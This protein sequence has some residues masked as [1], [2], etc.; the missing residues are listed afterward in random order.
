MKS[1]RNQELLIYP[2]ERRQRPVSLF[3]IISQIRLFSLRDS[4]QL[5]NCHGNVNVNSEFVHRRLM[6]QL[7]DASRR[8]CW[9]ARK[10]IRWKSFLKLSL[11]LIRLQ[12][13]MEGWIV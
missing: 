13:E 10:K 2:P 9:T 5:Y 3:L 12:K 8:L 11:L 6:Q 4:L 1:C 7:Y